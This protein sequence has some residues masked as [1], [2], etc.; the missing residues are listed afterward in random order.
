MFVVKR[1]V[2]IARVM[3]WVSDLLGLGPLFYSTQKLH[4][5]VHRTLTHPGNLTEK[6]SLI[7]TF[8]NREPDEG[9]VRG[10]WGGEIGWWV[11]Y[12]CRQAWTWTITQRVIPTWTITNQCCYTVTHTSPSSLRQTKWELHLTQSGSYCRYLYCF[13]YVYM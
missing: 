2:L 10:A 11:C 12:E 6:V 5:C 7:V 13:C 3:S 9:W 8:L 1:V 4:A